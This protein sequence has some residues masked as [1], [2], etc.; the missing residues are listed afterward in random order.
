MDISV[1]IPAFN[2][3]RYLPGTLESILRASEHLRSKAEVDVE[4]IVVDNN[5]TDETATVA[6]DMGA[7][8]IQE[9]VQGIGRA[10]NRGASDCHW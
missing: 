5:S 6:G 2:E 4:V 10:R 1:I 8:V 9:P 7:T 3:A